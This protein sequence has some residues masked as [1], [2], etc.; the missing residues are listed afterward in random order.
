MITVSTN[1]RRKDHGTGWG[2]PTGRFSLC[3]NFNNVCSRVTDKSF[4]CWFSY[5]LFLLSHTLET[6]RVELALGTLHCPS[7]KVPFFPQDVVQLIAPPFSLQ[8]SPLISQVPLLSKMT[9]KMYFWSPLCGES[10]NI[11]MALEH[12]HC[13][14]RIQVTTRLLNHGQRSTRLQIQRI[15]RVILEIACRPTLQI[16]EALFRQNWKRGHDVWT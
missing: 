6:D 10:S 11:I 16:T 2:F 15:I 1:V 8:Y 13:F 5:S 7:S 4:S 12:F 14:I 3:S 9:E